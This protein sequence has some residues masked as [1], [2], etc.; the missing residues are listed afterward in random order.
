MLEHILPLLIEGDQDDIIK[1][2]QMTNQ[3]KLTDT[4]SYLQDFVDE[5]S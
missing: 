3:G 2:A 1:R 4:F 5:K